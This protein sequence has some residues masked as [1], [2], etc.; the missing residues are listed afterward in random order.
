MTSAGTADLQP[1]LRG[2]LVHLEPL[3]PEHFD[4]LFAAASDPLIWEQ[5]PEST[6]Y[7]RP[8]FERFFAGALE[9]RGALL[10][11]DAVTGEVIGSSRYHAYD[12]VRRDVEI[13]WTFL[14]RSRWGGRFNG[15]MKRLMIEH[16]FRF[17]DSVIFIVGVTNYR[18]QRAVEKIGG[19]REGMRVDAN[20]RDNVVF[21]LSPDAFAAA[22]A[23]T[24]G[25]VGS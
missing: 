17:V 5:H 6:R 18:S 20:G 21:R 12:P 10:A 25:S 13:G 11:R 9:S 8:V 3:R 1:T 16:A 14:V 24:P 4:A 22:R 7:Q 23:G 19:V 2:E 15:E